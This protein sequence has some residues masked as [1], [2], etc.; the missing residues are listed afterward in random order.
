MGYVFLFK[1]NK[2]GAKWRHGVQHNPFN[3]DAKI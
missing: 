2:S 3:L 1:I